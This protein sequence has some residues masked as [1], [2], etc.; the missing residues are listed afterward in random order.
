MKRPIEK[1]PRHLTTAILVVSI[2]AAFHLFGGLAM[3]VAASSAASHNQDHGLFLALGLATFLA[4]ALLGV[5]AYGLST[6]ARWA[7][8]LVITL[9][10]LLMLN[11][12]SL[13]MIPAGGNVLGVIIG[14]ILPTVVLTNLTAS[15]AESWLAGYADD[16]TVRS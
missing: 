3:L 8:R 12:L 9:E 6:R 16:E 14:M 10:I 15:D 13:F 4:A 7:R 5:G 11:A 2:Q 1:R